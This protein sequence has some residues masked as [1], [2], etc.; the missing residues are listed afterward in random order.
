MKHFYFDTSALFK[1][2][3]D[4]AGSGFINTL[5]EHSN[6]NRYTFY[7][8]ILTGIEFCSAIRRHQRE[9]GI[10]EQIA[11]EI[12]HTFMIE[13]EK[14]LSTFPVENHLIQ[15]S[16][17]LIA[18]YPLKAYDAVQL[19]TCIEARDFSV[20]L[21]NFYFVCDDHQ[22]GEAARSEGIIV[23]NPRLDSVPQ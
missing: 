1:R 11:V 23:L 22:L 3:H 6:Q 21:N 19:A 17:N 18:K 8:S 10:D 12:I 16:M 7:T 14:T 5:F 15:C 9:G 13:S 2:Y 20:H 4:E